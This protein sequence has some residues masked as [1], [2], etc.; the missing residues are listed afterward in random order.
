M[1]KMRA[2]YYPMQRNLVLD[3]A[4]DPN[5]DYHVYLPSGIQG[6]VIITSRV[7]DCQQYSTIL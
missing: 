1:M 6:S 7:A 2:H 5:F 3:N 4:D